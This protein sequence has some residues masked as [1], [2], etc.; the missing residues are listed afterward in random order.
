MKTWVCA[1]VN[2]LGPSTSAATDDTCT[3]TLVQYQSRL[4]TIPIDQYRG[5]LGT[6]P[7]VDRLTRDER[8]RVLVTFVPDDLVSDAEKESVVIDAHSAWGA[9]VHEALGTLAASL[10]ERDGAGV[11]AVTHSGGNRYAVEGPT[12]SAIDLSDESVSPDQHARALDALKA[13]ASAAQHAWRDRARPAPS[14]FF[15]VYWASTS[16]WLARG[17]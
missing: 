8:G 7:L 14:A 11:I 15:R 6:P 13:I 2:Q 3:L 10:G 1:G 4:L 12:G 17:A 9:R 16:P 5:F